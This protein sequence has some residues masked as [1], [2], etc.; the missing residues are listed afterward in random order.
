MT[1]QRWASAAAA[2][3]AV[4]VLVAALASGGGGGAVPGGGE[5]QT[6]GAA[7]ADPVPYDG[8][9]PA[10]PTGRTERVL[11]QLPRPA[12]GARKDVA[13][14]RPRRQRFYVR[15][16]RQEAS[17]LISALAATGVRLRD[18]ATFERT[19]HGFAATI[20]AADLPRLQSLGVRVRANRRFYPAFSEPVPV[21]AASRPAPPRHGPRVTLLAG[22]VSGA[23][24]GGYDAVQRDSDPAPGTD[25]RD[26][27]RREV[28]GTP[29]ADALSALGATTRAVR[30]TALDGGEESGRTDQ[31]LAGLERTVDPNLDGDASDHDYVAVIGV[32]APYAGFADAAETQAMAAAKRLG[33]L[34]VAPGGDEGPAAG[35]Y[36]TVGSPGAAAGALA[37]AA[38]GDPAAVART[39]LTVGNSTVSGAAL[40]AGGPPR[41]PLRTAGPVEAVTAAALLA[42]GAPPLQGRM[43][44][45]RAG[46]NPGAQAAAA[47]AAGAAAVLVAEPRPDR[48]LPALAA[49]RVAVPVLGVTGP[50]AGAILA[51]RAG[52]P[53]TATGVQAP[54][55]RP[56]TPFA[57]S[58]PS[59]LASVGPAY[60][61]TDKPD[62][63]RPGC[64]VAGG[65]LICG[66]AL[67]AA[68]VA[69]EA[70]MSADPDVDAVRGRLLAP[71]DAIR[72][73][74]RAARPVLAA[75]AVPIGP[76]RVKRTRRATGVEFT[77]G[78]FDRG[79]PAGGLG[80]E[81]VPAAALQLTLK[82]AG[83]SERLTPPGGERGVLPGVYAYTLPR[84][85][86]AR[87]AAGSYRFTV[88]AKA[89]RQAGAPTRA[90]SAPF[91]VR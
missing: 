60:D 82:G 89:P 35:A 25:A 8:R 2:A 15:S 75:P 49:G 52:L 84:S 73:S 56:G 40:L 90:A 16:L 66:A 76:L 74:A 6:F 59:R 48:P 68:Q 28:G 37:V 46:V 85:V 17:A 5:T 54:A 31:L 47:A 69:V 63:A 72:R 36:G 51:L 45:V 11:V 41:K 14:L 23:L 62:L 64:L 33:T 34:V 71:T 67:A 27:G 79:D 91:K 57:A 1:R 80:T 10:L 32:S 55:D 42:K 65:R 4:L 29:L 13:R 50:A 43:A 30:V 86:L 70:A 12:L 9:S 83:V 18:V 19:W 20:R 53:A 38:L 44:V 3:V 22:G 77:V 24:K 39:K 87:L 81:I 7:L 88:R 26:P 21:G 61:G 58:G 78:R